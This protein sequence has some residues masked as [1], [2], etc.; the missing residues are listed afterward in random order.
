MV[1]KGL[2]RLYF[3]FF[4]SEKFSISSVEKISH[5]MG[6]RRRG[7]FR[8]ALS[9]RPE[10]VKDSLFFVKVKKKEQIQGRGIACAVQ[11]EVRGQ[12]KYFLL[13]DT[14]VINEEGSRVFAHRCYRPW[15][16]TNRNIVDVVGNIPGDSSFSFIPLDGAPKKSLKLISFDNIDDRLSMPTCRSFVAT[17][18]SLKTVYWIYNSETQ[19][20]QLRPGNSEL[21]EPSAAL[22][23]P[24]LWTDD[25]NQSYVVGVIRRLSNGIFFPGIF[26]RSTLQLLGENIIIAYFVFDSFIFLFFGLAWL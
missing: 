23:S 6:D 21:E 20:H 3:F 18:K 10:D 15:Y 16:S 12:T 22:G 9:D 11:T 8:R 25:A 26:D 14:D 1:F 24:V 5:T 4:F 19:R 2:N 17:Q 7:F 13:T